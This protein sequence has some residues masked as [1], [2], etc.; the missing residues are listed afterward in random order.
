[1]LRAF[2]IVLLMFSVSSFSQEDENN[3]SKHRFYL[4]A[5]GHGGFGSLNYERN[6]IKIE[7]EK[8]HWT[9]RT[10]LSFLP[11]D[12]NSGY[13]L[14]FPNSINFLYGKKHMLEVGL[15][16]VFTINLKGSL[17]MR[18][19]PVLGY[20]FMSNENPW[21]ARLTYTPFISH[22]WDFRLSQWAGFSVGYQFK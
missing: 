11:G 7:N 17:F 6:L 13:S 1:V 10:G 14:I 20:R 12:A 15:G 3:F 19:M 4:E 9:Y 16:E 5:F 22:I 8:S 18:M 2:A 21:F